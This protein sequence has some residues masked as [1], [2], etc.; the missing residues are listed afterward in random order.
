M[1]HLSN[2]P[3]QAKTHSAVINNAILSHESARSLDLA[4]PLGKTCENVCENENHA[5]TSFSDDITAAIFSGQ[6]IKDFL[7]YDEKKQKRQQ[8]RVKVAIKPASVGNFLALKRLSE[9]Q[10]FKNSKHPERMKLVDFNGSDFNKLTEIHPN[11]TLSDF[12]YTEFKEV[13]TI[14]TETGEIF[15]FKVKGKGKKRHYVLQTSMT[16]IED[17]F[18]MQKIMA[19]LFPQHRVSKCL[20]CVQSNSKHL[21]VFKSRSHGAISLSNLQTCGSVWLDPVCAS[22]ITEKR[23]LEIKFGMDTHKA[24]GGSCTFVTRTFPHT[25]ADSLISLRQRLRKAEKIMKANHQYRKMKSAFGIIGD[26]ETLE[27]TVSWHNGWHLHV[28]EIY[29]HEQGTFNGVADCTNPEYVAFLENF[30]KI[31][32]EIWHD[33]TLKAG[34]DEISREHGLTVQNGDFAADYIAKFGKEPQSNWGADAE[35]TKAHIKK[36][37]SGF[38]PWDLIRL[39]RDTGD[40]DLVPII[41]EYGNSMFGANQIKWS[42]GLK[43]RLG[44]GEKTD[45]E[46]AEELDDVADEIGVLSPVQWKFIVKNDLRTVFYLFAAEGWDVVTDFLQSYEHYPA[47]SMLPED[48]KKS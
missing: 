19:K 47:F 10:K 38:T 34:F 36:S 5:E 20:C 31:F 22:K 43:K 37:R 46:L 1:T 13:R 25:K 30:E 12:E 11:L 32:F 44:V 29:F 27:I 45:E 3:L 14:D 26:I 16:A 15:T 2:L 9:V 41:Q 42:K 40:Q 33:V 48:F 8:K 24:D 39:Y 23:R 21:S 35:L 18:S 4:K 17:R 28:H 7:E 6:S